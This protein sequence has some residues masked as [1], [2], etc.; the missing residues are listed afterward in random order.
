MLLDV[1]VGLALLQ[2]RR[3]VTRFENLLMFRFYQVTNVKAEKNLSL[4]ETLLE[5]LLNSN[6]WLVRE[7]V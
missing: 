3:R 6:R 2:F 1:L 7:L 5:K 4:S